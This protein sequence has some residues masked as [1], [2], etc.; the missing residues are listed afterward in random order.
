M[1]HIAKRL[2]LLLGIY[3]KVVRKLRKC[4]CQREVS[5]LGLGGVM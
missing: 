1:K 3:L 4:S 2:M 5:G